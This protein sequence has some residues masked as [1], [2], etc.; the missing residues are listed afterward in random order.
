MSKFF[1]G[2]VKMTFG[3]VDV[4]YS[5]T[6]KLAFLHPTNNMLLLLK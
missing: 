4:S 3:Q 5:Q 6:V 1:F 2:R